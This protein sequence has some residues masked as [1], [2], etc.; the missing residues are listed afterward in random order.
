MLRGPKKLIW[1]KGLATSLLVVILF[2]IIVKDLQEA[3][4]R[5]LLHISR[6][7]VY[8]K[9]DRIE[10]KTKMGSLNSLIPNSFDYL[11]NLS[12]QEEVDANKVR[13]YVRYYN[14]VVDFIPK[15]AGAYGILGFC[16][17]YLGEYEK[18]FYAYQKAI[19][20][21]PAFFWFHYNLGLIYFNTGQYAEAVKAFQK[22][23]QTRADF[24]LMT[25]SSSKVYIQLR[26]LVE[27]F[28][29]AALPNLQQA[30]QNS[31]KLLILSYYQLNDFPSVIATATY[32]IDNKLDEQGVFSYYAGLA[33]Y[34]MRRYKEAVF[35]FQECLKKNPRNKDALYSLGLTLKALGKIAQSQSILQQAKM[36]EQES[37]ENMLSKDDVKLHIF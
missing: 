15:Q 13:E 10:S 3:K 27:G 23:T 37:S 30:Y 19:A 2:V 36:L 22:A 24:T 8:K 35:S 14:Q 12:A 6:R 16:Y 29:D 20:L 4:K 32:A 5:I 9:H 21:N 17:Y 11:V 25:M 7:D 33:A 34:K 18:A 28:E 1:F 31:F 26:L